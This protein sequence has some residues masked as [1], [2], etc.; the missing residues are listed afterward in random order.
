VALE[1]MAGMISELAIGGLPKF[2]WWK[3]NPQPE[4]PLFQRLAA[5][6]D[7][8]IIDSS[9][10]ENPEA[11]LKQVGEL[12]AGNAS[13]ADLNWE[14]LAPWQELTAQAFDPPE[15]RAAIPEVDRLT[16]DYEQ[17]NVAQAL[18]FLG[19]VASRLQWQP[20][21]YSYEGGDYDIRRV[22]F[23]TADQRAIEAELAGIPLT[24]AGEVL[25]D[26]ISIKM[27]S[28]NLQAD[29][30]TVICSGTTGCMRMEAGGGAQA[31]RIQQ[32]AALDDQKTEG[33]IVRQLQRWGQDQLYVEGMG[34]AYQ[35]SSHRNR[36]EENL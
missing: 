23:T 7:T 14:R 19:W 2:V 5:Q 24:D 35:F 15:R 34:V 3:A 26:L 16:I 29:C 13:L 25:G 12:L 10:F 4:S 22:T 28:T 18:M 17:G 21:S 32:V 36:Q 11:S 33:L 8:T 31:C 27:S 1:Q 6:C 20:A 9:D 30:C